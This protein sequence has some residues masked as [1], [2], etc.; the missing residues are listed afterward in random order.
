[1]IVLATSIL[2]QQGWHWNVLAWLAG[3]LLLLIGVVAVLLVTVALRPGR[4]SAFQRS[5]FAFGPATLAAPMLFLACRALQLIEPS[6]G[7]GPQ[8]W[9][10][11]W[12]PG[13]RH[14]FVPPYDTLVAVHILSAALTAGL[15]ILVSLVVPPGAGRRSAPPL[16]GRSVAAGILGCIAVVVP[17]LAWRVYTVDTDGSRL[18]EWIAWV[19]T[20]AVVVAL[21]ANA[22][23][24]PALAGDEREPG[25]PPA[26][27]PPDA[28]AIWIAAGLLEPSSV[29]LRRVPARESGDE[30]SVRAE[31]AWTA[32][33]GPARPPMALDVLLDRLPDSS[34]LYVLGDVPSDAEHALFTALL[35][36]LVGQAGLRVLVVHPRP[37]GLLTDVDAAIQRARTWSS[38]ASVNGTDAL[39]EALAGHQL[40]ALTAVTPHAFANRLIRMVGQEAR[41]WMEGLDLLLIHRPDLG[42]PIE[43][44][45]TS[46]AIRRWHLATRGRSVPAALVTVPGSPAHRAFAERLFPGRR[47]H[48]VDYAPRSV[49]E[50]V[51]WP[52]REPDTDA[53]VPWLARAARPLTERDQ[54]VTVVDPSG[55][56]STDALP[57]GVVVRREPSWHHHASVAELSPGDLVEALGSLGNRLPSPADHTSLWA[58]PRDPVSRFLHPGRLATLTREGRL[59]RPAPVV[60]LNNRFLRLSHLDVAL[61]EA[62]ND[63]RSLRSAFGDDLVDFRL[64]TTSE[65]A[66]RSLHHRSWRDGDRVVRSPHLRGASTSARPQPGTVTGDTVQILEARSGEALFEVDART[67]P[68]RFYPKRVFA[69]GD[70]RFLVPMHAFDAQRRQLKVELAG[71]LDRVTL[72]VLSFDLDLRR[73]TVEQVGR[74]QGPFQMHTTSAECLVK[75]RVHAA[76]VPGRDQEERF[77][78]VESSYDT[79]VRF[80]F[81]AGAT[82]G[83]ELFHLAACVEAFLPVFLRCDRADVSVVPVRAGFVEGRAAGIGVVDRFVGGMG[84]AEALDDARLQEILAWTRAMLYECP[85]MDGCERCTPPQVLRVGP[86]KQRVLQLLEGL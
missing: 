35:A 29:P 52:G 75:E 37:A 20:L 60:G 72:P 9:L 86:A 76:W 78:V 26:P 55:R 16:P 13:M 2:H 23:L 47:A 3:Y 27:V 25:P 8:H 39:H 62:D 43:V 50:S 11:G 53:V 70:R 46:F 34:D 59:P 48:R 21:R 45:H 30:P 41:G 24:P 6:F 32:V 38:G 61:L 33:Q 68:T 65:P 82:K 73:I 79:I 83:L 1:M 14:A 64:R 44:T 74:R 57:D 81:P 28:R 84:F 18:L 63:E 7:P 15:A 22:W 85:C 49:G 19:P 51:A 31:R 77:G 10:I 4:G 36:D 58:L 17:F 12:L 66:S 42:T 71:E 80:V 40:P 56:W 67:A 5:L 54:A 69:L